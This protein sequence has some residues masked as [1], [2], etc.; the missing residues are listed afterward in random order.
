MCT[1][2]GAGVRYWGAP[3][4]PARLTG[5]MAVVALVAA[6]CFVVLSVMLAGGSTATD[7]DTTAAT[8]LPR[9]YRLARII[10]FAGEPAGALGLGVAMVIVLTA[11]GRAR[12]AV[13]AVLAQCVVGGGGIPLKSAVDRTINGGFLSFPSG[14]TAG[15]TAFAAVVA[16]A[17]ACRAGIGRAGTLAALALVPLAGLLAGWAQVMLNAHYATDALG[18]FLLALVVVPA[19]AWLVDRVA[20]RVSRSVHRP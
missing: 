10:D 19:L 18:G 20:I 9:D 4:L 12:S 7:V 8:A 5:P 16:L 11:I 17:L 15:L 13:V 1:E 6:C 2:S 14:H 3:A